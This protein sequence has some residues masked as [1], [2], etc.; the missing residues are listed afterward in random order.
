MNILYGLLSIVVGG[1]AII[2]LLFMLKMGEYNV[3]HNN[4]WTCTKYDLIGKAP[5]RRERCVEL[6]RI[7]RE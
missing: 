1:L 6:K 7:N 3:V 2:G 4:E 5:E